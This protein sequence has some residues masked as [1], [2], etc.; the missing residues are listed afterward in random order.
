VRSKGLRT[1]LNIMLALPD[2][3][4]SPPLERAQFFFAL[5]SPRST[6]P[7]DEGGISGDLTIFSSTNGALCAV[8]GA[9]KGSESHDGLS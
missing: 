2:I 1:E 4:A 3:V 6:T 5:N 9:K 8:K 7:P